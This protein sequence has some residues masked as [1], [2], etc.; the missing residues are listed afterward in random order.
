MNSFE[1]IN[2]SVSA[3]EN[4]IKSELFTSKSIYDTYNFTS[5]NYR[6]H[7]LSGF[8]EEI[9]NELDTLPQDEY[10]IKKL[11]LLINSLQSELDSDPVLKK[12]T[13]SI[14]AQKSHIEFLISELTKKALS[15]EKTIFDKRDD[16]KSDMTCLTRKE[17][18]LLFRYLQLTNSILNHDQIS[19]RELCKHIAALTHISDAQLRKELTGNSWTDPTEISAK[20]ENFD[21]VKSVL[22]L[23]IDRIKSDSKPF[24]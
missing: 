17:T 11:N 16:F 6:T 12:Q 15:I 23:I 14:R 4:Q 1:N 22:E 7:F 21:K 8:I 3:I 13:N 20:R 9:N 24:N 18:A 19:D 5:P 10:L 2:Q